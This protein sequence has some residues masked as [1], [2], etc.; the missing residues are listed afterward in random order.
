[1]RTILD[2]VRLVAAEKKTTVN[3]MVREF[4]ADVASRDEKAWR[5]RESG[6]LRADAKSRRAEWRPD[7]KFDREETHER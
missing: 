6:L 4:L 7:F 3:A 1:M 2:G 5:R